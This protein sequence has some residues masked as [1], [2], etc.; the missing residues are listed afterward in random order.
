MSEPVELQTLAGA[1]VRVHGLTDLGAPGV[2]RVALAIDCREFN[3][4]TVWVSLTD[5]EARA[6]ADALTGATASA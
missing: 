4:G 1:H 5:T 2:T 3:R 6:V